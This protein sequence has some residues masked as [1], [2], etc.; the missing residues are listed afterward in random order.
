MKADDR[1]FDGFG[2]A[3]GTMSCHYLMHKQVVAA[4]AWQNSCPH[5]VRVVITCLCIKSIFR[6]PDDWCINY[7]HEK[8]GGTNDLSWDF[9]NHK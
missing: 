7:I 4:L 8:Y 2:V 3:G 9:F 6:L 1:R 5:E